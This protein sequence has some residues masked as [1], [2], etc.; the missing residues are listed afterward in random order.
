MGIWETSSSTKIN[1]D[2]NRKNSFKY[3][4]QVIKS[5]DGWFKIFF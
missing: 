5:I 2:L 4:A 3:R 1:K